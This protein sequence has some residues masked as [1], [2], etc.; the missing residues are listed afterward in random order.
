M[1]DPTVL[2]I[3]T[4]RAPLCLQYRK[5]FNVSAVSPDWDMKKHTSSLNV[6]K[7]VNYHLIEVVINQMQGFDPLKKNCLPE[8]WRISIKE[9][10]C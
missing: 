5:A 10:R 3:P 6:K 1:V 2:V 7:R 8:N 4:I 9:V